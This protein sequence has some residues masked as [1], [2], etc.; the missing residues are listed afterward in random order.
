MHISSIHVLSVFMIVWNFSWAI[1]HSL[2]VICEL[3]SDSVSSCVSILVVS[4]NR[5]SSFWMFSCGIG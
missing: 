2:G 1:S 3:C 5:I 4:W